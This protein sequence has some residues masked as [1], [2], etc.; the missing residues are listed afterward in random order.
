M[1]QVVADIRHF[2]PLTLSVVLG[3]W[4]YPNERNSSPVLIFNAEDTVALLTK[5]NSMK[6]AVR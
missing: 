4:L 5:F 1:D 6:S 3:M 2:K